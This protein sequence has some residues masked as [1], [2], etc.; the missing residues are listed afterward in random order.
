MPAAVFFLFALGFL[1]LRQVGPVPTAVRLFLSLTTCGHL[2]YNT[3]FQLCFSNWKYTT[4][5]LLSSPCDLELTNLSPVLPL[6]EQKAALQWGP[7]TAS[8]LM[9]T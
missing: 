4:Y 9:Q 6:S 1:G 5:A 2:P 7:S 8:H 3:I